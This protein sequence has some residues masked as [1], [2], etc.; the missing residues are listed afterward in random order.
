[1]MV[2]QAFGLPVNVPFVNVLVYVSAGSDVRQHLS[3]Q[4]GFGGEEKALVQ[5]R[6]FSSYQRAP[7]WIDPP[8]VSIKLLHLTASLQKIH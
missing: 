6:D 5:K 3:T 7:K 2:E 1:M 4:D 8:I